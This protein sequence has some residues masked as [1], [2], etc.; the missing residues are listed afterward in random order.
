MKRVGKTQEHRSTRSLQQRQE[1]R[2]SN[3]NAGHEKGS[4]SGGCPPQALQQL[5][6]GSQPLEGRAGGV[7]QTKAQKG[8]LGRGLSSQALQAVSGRLQKQNHG[9]QHGDT[10]AKEFLKLLRRQTPR[11]QR[12]RNRVKH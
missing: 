4:V 11:A 6:E 10:V 8:I 5:R 3:A 9:G 1:L 12:T 7:T 2:V